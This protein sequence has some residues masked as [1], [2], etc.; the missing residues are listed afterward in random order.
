MSDRGSDKGAGWVLFAAMVM[1]VVG[2][3]SMLMGLFGLIDD[4]KVTMAG[5]QLFI[6]DITTW[7]WMHILLGALVLFTGLGLF[8]G[9]GLAQVVAV[10]LVTINAIAQ[11]FTMSLHPWWGLTMLVLDIF[12]IWALCVYRP[13]RI[14]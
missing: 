13:A 8:S 10:F 4:E 14:E 11:L 12:I 3:W 6:V 2:G 9:S 1:V 7:A 5:G